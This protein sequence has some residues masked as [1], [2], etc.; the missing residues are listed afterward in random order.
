LV[1]SYE[2]DQHYHLGLR[3]EGSRLDGSH[4]STPLAN[5]REKKFL[6]MDNV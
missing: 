5:Q 2:E 4:F 1:I 6:I 3:L